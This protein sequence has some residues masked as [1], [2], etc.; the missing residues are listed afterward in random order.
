MRRRR[1]DADRRA[2]ARDERLGRERAPGGERLLD[3]LDVAAGGRQADEHRARVLDRGDDRARRRRGRPSARASDV[4]SHVGASAGARTTTVGASAPASS[5]RDERRDRSRPAGS[6]PRGRGTRRPAPVARFSAATSSAVNAPVPTSSPSTATRV[7]RAAH[8]AREAARAPRRPPAT[9]AGC[10]RGSSAR[11][12][13]S[14]IGARARLDGGDLL[15]GQAVAPHLGSGA[16]ERAREPALLVAEIDLR[17][18]RDRRRTPGAAAASTRRMRST[19]SRTTSSARDVARSSV[20]PRWKSSFNGLSTASVS[21]STGRGNG[22]R[23]TSATGSP[24]FSSCPAVTNVR[25][26]RPADRGADRPHAVGTRLDDGGHLAGAHE[27]ALDQRRELDAEVGERLRRQPGRP[28]VVGV[29]RLAGVV[30]GVSAPAGCAALSAGDPAAVE[31]DPEDQAA[32]DEADDDPA[33]EPEA[34]TQRRRRSR[35]NRCP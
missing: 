13:T 6:A 23:T 14:G 33:D 20:M 35:R 3:P 21:A 16:F 9:R 10:A 32:G 17:L 22:S 18:R 15:V 12:G 30:A 7:G 34:R 28:G 11:G 25:V 27:L 1:M 4:T 5:P 19:S 24:A 8:A 29:P 31:P 26:T 2:R